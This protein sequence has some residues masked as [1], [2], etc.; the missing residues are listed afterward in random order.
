MSMSSARV[1]IALMAAA[2]MACQD[3]STIGGP[4]DDGANQLVVPGRTYVQ[5]EFLA[6]PLVS[7]VTVPKAQHHA[8]NTTMPY[9]RNQFIPVTQQF[10]TGFGRPQALAELLATV[11]YSNGVGD[12]LL[13]YPDRDPATTGWL[14]WALQP[15]VGAGGR[16][17]TDDVVDLGLT[18]IFSSFLNPAGALC[19]PFQLPLCTDNVP[20]TAK[21]PSATFPYLAGPF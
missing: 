19:Q 3:G 7:E 4:L 12:M 16:R 5:I 9:A 17:L 10:V 20:A 21:A 2:V 15:G 14:S 18:A 11:L 13:F 1:T 6:N 8:Y